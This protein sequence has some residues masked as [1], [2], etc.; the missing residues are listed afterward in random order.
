MKAAVYAG[1]RTVAVQERPVPV[2]S[3]GE[4][5]VAVDYCGICG[6]DLHSVME[7]WGRPGAIL[8]HE[9]SGRIAEVGRGVGG[10]AVGSGVLPLNALIAPGAVPLANIM[11][12]MEDLAAGHTAAKVLVAPGA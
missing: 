10:W 2:P 4:V 6:T 7:G 8:G 9:Y 11:S 1:D 3:A 5:V 12:A